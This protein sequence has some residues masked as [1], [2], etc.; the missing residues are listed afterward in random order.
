[1]DGANNPSR[2]AN[3]TLIEAR[4][5]VGRFAYLAKRGVDEISGDSAQL[6]AAAPAPLPVAGAVSVCLHPSIR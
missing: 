3:V 6:A 5:L 1:M 2:H 4:P